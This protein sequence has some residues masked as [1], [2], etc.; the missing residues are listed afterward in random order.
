MPRFS[1]Q[2]NPRSGRV[3]APAWVMPSGY[4]VRKTAA[5]IAALSPEDR[6]QYLEDQRIADF[7]ILT[8][9]QILALSPA[10]RAEY[11]ET[12]FWVLGREGSAAEKQRLVNPTEAFI[13]VAQN[14]IG[15]TG[16]VLLAAINGA[17]LNEREAIRART[18]IRLAEIRASSNPDP[19]TIAA[20]SQTSYLLGQQPP[21]GPTY[22]SGQNVNNNRNLYLIGGVVAVAIIGG[23]L[24]MSTQKRSNPVVRVGNKR[25]KK[26]IP[27]AKLRKIR[28]KRSRSRS[29]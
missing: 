24:Y 12:R 8:P 29:R 25:S 3:P 5:E 19:N 17:N 9:A 7:Q 18:E 11:A 20:L 27:A 23:A 2:E 15:V 22:G 13:P 16:D 10:A 6:V 21:I 28:A 4:F 26:F 14:A 1:V